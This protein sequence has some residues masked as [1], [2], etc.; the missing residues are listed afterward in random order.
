M[1]NFRSAHVLDSGV[2]AGLRSYMLRVYDYMFLALALT[3]LVSWGFFK[4]TVVGV[5]PEGAVMVNRL[6]LLLTNP[7]FNLVLGFSL[8]GM[9]FYLNMN[10]QS[11]SASTAQRLFF[12]YAAL[13]GISL[14]P[15]ALVYTA[16]SIART[17]LITSVSFGA[18]SLYGYTTKRDLTPMA[19]FLMIGVVGLLLAIIANIFIHS[20][21]L[22][23]AISLVG[24]LIFAGLTAWD[25]QNI[26]MMYFASSQGFGQQKSAVFG[27]IR[28]YIDFLNMFLFFL[29]FTGDR[30]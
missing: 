1:D 6:G 24:V 12:A 3:A 7:V 2:N 14:A 23:F 21:G 13:V 15:I 10:L 22:D 16:A 19:S 18:L 26:K 28:L 4:L 27:A 29:H 17:F 30:R 20:S 8:L 5:T 25:T 9:L 11:M